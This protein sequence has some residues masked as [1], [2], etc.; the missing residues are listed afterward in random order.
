MRRICF[1]FTLLGLLALA[2]RK[3]NSKTIGTLAPGVGCDVWVIQV[4]GAGYLQPTNWSAFPSVTQ[5]AGQQ[6]EFTYS[7][8]NE[9]TTCMMGPA[10]RL[11]DI[12][13]YP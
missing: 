8:E 11:D 10:V 9:A 13:D 2:C 1:L 6:V 4:H 12:W 7:V 3:S 5:K